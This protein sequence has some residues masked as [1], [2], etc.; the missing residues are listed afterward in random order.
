MDIIAYT[1]AKRNEKLIGAVKAQ[2]MTPPSLTTAQ[3]GQKTME[4]TNIDID[5]LVVTVNGKIISSTEYNVDAK[6]GVVTFKYG[7]SKGDKV[8]ITSDYQEEMVTAEK[9]G[10]I[11]DFTAAL[12]EK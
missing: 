1:M 6:T 3:D 8:S 12:T 7:L 2:F 11:D 4:A 5:T 9:I 10:T